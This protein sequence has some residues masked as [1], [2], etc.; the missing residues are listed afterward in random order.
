LEAI[1]ITALMIYITYDVMY[2]DMYDVW[3]ASEIDRG[4]D[5]ND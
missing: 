3:S 2:D 1:K 4:F 5:F